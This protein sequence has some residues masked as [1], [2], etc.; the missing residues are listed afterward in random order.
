MVV[1]GDCVEGD[2]CR[3][4]LGV[5]IAQLTELRPARGSPNRRSEKDDNGGASV[6]VTVKINRFSGGVWENEIGKGLADIRAGGMA[7]G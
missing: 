6:S 5:C 2:S 1:I 7:I 4:E 3:L